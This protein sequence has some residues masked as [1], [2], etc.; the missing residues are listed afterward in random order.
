MIDYKQLC[1][2]FENAWMNA[3]DYN[4]QFDAANDLA[5]AIGLALNKPAPNVYY[6][7][8]VIND[9]DCFETGGDALTFSEIINEARSC[10]AEYPNDGKW[11]CEIRRIEAIRVNR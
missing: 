7:F 3:K 9:Q 4:E 6:E 5:F 11:R 1:V 2:D 10:F 8:C